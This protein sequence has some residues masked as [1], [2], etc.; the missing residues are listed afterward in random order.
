[1]DALAV[2]RRQRFAGIAFI[3]AAMFAIAA[4]ISPE[5]RTATWNLVPLAVLMSPVILA[6]APIVIRR[7]G[8]RPVQA[9]VVAT[10]VA[11]L[12]DALPIVLVTLDPGAANV[13]YR[14]WWVGVTT[15][16]VFALMSAPWAAWRR[17]DWA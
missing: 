10:V 8:T 4:L 1:M 11:I 14:L 12:A 6:L 5:F 16:Y 3:G 7:G 13:S 2:G 15:V 17:G 9:L